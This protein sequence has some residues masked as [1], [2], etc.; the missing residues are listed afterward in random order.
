VEPGVDSVAHPEPAAGQPFGM[1][2]DRGAVL[3]RHGHAAELALLG[4]GVQPSRVLVQVHA[5]LA[6]WPCGS[7]PE[8]NTTVCSVVVDLR[9][10]SEGADHVPRP[11]EQSQADEDEQGRMPHPSSPSAILAAMP[12]LLAATIVFGASAAVLVLEILAGRLMA[13]YVGVTLETFTAIIGT[14]L[15]GIAAGSW[16]GGKAADRYE[17]RRL[18]GP[19]VV[20]GGVLALLSIPIV[21]YLGYGTGSAASRASVLLLAATGFFLPAAALSAVT[22]T[23]VKMQ[24]GDLANT[25]SIVGRLSAVSTAGAL[26]GTFITGF[27]LV[28]AWP[29]RPIIHGIGILLVIAGLALWLWLW[30]RD[31]RPTAALM[32]VIVVAALMPFVAGHPCEQES[33]YFCV[34]VVEDPERA[35]GR[36]L[37]LDTYRNSYVDLEDPTYLGFTYSQTL[38][39]V[40]EAVFP[41][42]APISAAHIG[43]GGMTMPSYLRATRPG[44][45]QTVM[46][47]D[48]LVVATA[49]DEL[50]FELGPDVAIV[51][52]DARLNIRTIPEGSLDLLVGDAFSGLSVPWHLTTREF[53][54]A[55]AD[56]LSPNGV[57]A[58]NL[59]DYPPLAFAR[60]EAATLAEVFDNVAI[61][62]PAERLRGDRGPNFVLVASNADLP[63]EDIL[64]RN[65]ARGDD[66]AA[67]GSWGYSSQN[68]IGF[69][70]FT[71]GAVILTDDFAP[72]DQLMNPYP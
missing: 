70:E 30:P 21:D 58:L 44:S 2:E 8:N 22:P 43:G 41:G 31:Q 6:R 25:G 36:I 51:T 37:Y 20:A 68:D 52:G 15:A 13:P 63:I 47:L 29:T 45:A 35:T 55:I 18:L 11:K 26:V 57:Y 59:I 12:S 34:R 33:A 32:S 42:D 7:L 49:V 48:P 46:E 27:V 19:E 72:V 54:T 38:S 67:V 50:A 14:I 65:A 69:D 10:R 64:A 16:L 66:E 24:L 53:V 3:P 23:V 17:P 28:A 62:A 9:R 71:D 56:R 39:D 61:L 1:L 60:A 5:F 40:I 4:L